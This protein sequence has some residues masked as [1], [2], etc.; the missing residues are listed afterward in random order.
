MLIAILRLMRN[1]KE[2]HIVKRLLCSPIGIVFSALIL[3]VL[4]KANYSLYLRNDA[5][6]E[7]RETL[8]RELATL[9]H[10]KDRLTATLGRIGTEKGEEIALREQYDVGKDGE[11]LLVV[12]DL[13]GTQHASDEQSTLW[14]LIRSFIPFI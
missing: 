6:R 11:E 5:A 2:A 8:Q 10:R 9:E 3:F 14:G 12:I 4:L 7:N 13:E 1:R